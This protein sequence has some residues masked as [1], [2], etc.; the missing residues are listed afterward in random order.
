M[1]NPTP[2]SAIITPNSF[3]S[4]LRHQRKGAMATELSEQLAELTKA[5]SALTKPGKLTLT[6]KLTPAGDGAL[7]VFD[8]I[9]IKP[10]KPDK[11]NSIFF[12]NEHG[13]LLRE[14]PNQEEF[15]LQV[16][17]PAPAAEPLK[18]LNA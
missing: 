8:E 10:P 4:F 14:D 13:A 16:V 18:E 17:A 2:H 5:C 7:A 3:E 9:E 12:T 11:P 15:D 6:L 1:N